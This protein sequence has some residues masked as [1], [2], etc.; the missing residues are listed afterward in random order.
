M[1]THFIVWPEAAVPVL[2]PAGRADGAGGARVAV[3][4]PRLGF[5]RWVPT[6]NKG[7][8]S[9]TTRPLRSQP[10]GSIPLPVSQAN[11]DP[12]RRVD[13][14]RLTVFPW[15]KQ[16]EPQGR[17]R[18]APGTEVSV[19]TSPMQR[20][21]GTPYTLEVARPLICYEDTIPGLSREAVKEGA[22]LLVNLT[23]DTWF[24]RT[25]APEQH[26][27]IAA[28]RA[29]ENG[30]YLVRAT[31]SG[32]S[33]VVDPLGGTTALLPMFTDGVVGDGLLAQ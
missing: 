7:P 30:R 18:F 2:I 20:A 23:Y 29:V 4:R 26:H 28:F 19:S 32:F 17:R 11:P 12:V 5:S 33:A 3:D 13:P 14:A 22:N 24:G 1:N 8:A 6:R 9:A 31:N 25:V 16:L 15:L 27:L 21:N 10:D